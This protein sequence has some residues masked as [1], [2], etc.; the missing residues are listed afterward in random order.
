MKSQEK[1]VSG[2]S[3]KLTTYIPIAI[4]VISL[5]FGIFQYFDARESKERLGRAELLAKQKEAESTDMKIK[6][7]NIQADQAAVELKTKEI[8]RQED[9]LALLKSKTQVLPR[10]D[11]EYL[12]ANA[13][14]FYV[15]MTDQEDEE[16]RKINHERFS[17]RFHN[18]I[19][20]LHSELPFAIKK[21]NFV[22]TTPFD[23]LDKACQQGV[24]LDHFQFLLLRNTGGTR[25]SDVSVQWYEGPGSG[26]T[27]PNPWHEVQI[28]TIEPDQA[29]IFIVDWESKDK[30]HPLPKMVARSL[31]VLDPITGQDKT[32][33]I[34]LPRDTATIVAA[35][36]HWAH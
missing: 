19:G 28:G 16:P 21:L 25:A 18:W 33:E 3:A 6:I 27:S 36:I 2:L 8:T 7:G 30:K 17:K 15:T 11:V 24:A 13:D 9:E 26:K 34:R 23:D 32:S 35:N 20:L 31:T 22:D 14:D 5:F 12:T 29:A 10:V 1:D 4:S